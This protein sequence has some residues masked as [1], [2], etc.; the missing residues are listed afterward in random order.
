MFSLPYSFLYVPIYKQYLASTVIS[1]L[2]KFIAN[3]S[4]ELYKSAAIT[5]LPL[6]FLFK[7]KVYT[8]SPLNKYLSIL[9]VL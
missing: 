3:F 6:Y 1:Y 2:L 9:L 7:Y 8:F 4:G 5:F